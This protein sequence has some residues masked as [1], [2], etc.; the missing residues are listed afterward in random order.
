MHV[1]GSEIFAGQVRNPVTE[2]IF[3]RRE[4]AAPLAVKGMVD[5]KTGVEAVAV[6]REV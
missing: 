3:T 1:R 2:L 6:M 4:N 5:G